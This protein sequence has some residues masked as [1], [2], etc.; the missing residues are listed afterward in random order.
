MHNKAPP[1]S[2]KVYTCPDCGK[3]YK[4]PVALKKHSY[5]HNGKELPFGCNICGKRFLVNIV[6][7]EHLM[8][9]AGIKNYVCPY[10][11]LGFTSKP[12]CNKHINTHTREKTFKCPQCD[13]STH[14][15]HLLNRHIRVIHD[16]IKK[17]ICQYCSKAFSQSNTWRNHEKL[18]TGERPY[19]CQICDKNYIYA[20]DLKKHLRS[21]ENK[22]KRALK[23]EEKNALKME[24]TAGKKKRRRRKKIY[25][26]DGNFV[27]YEPPKNP[28]EN[29]MANVADPTN[30]LM[31]ATDILKVCEETMP[32][33]V[34]QHKPRV[35]RISLE[36]FAGTFVNPIPAVDVPGVPIVNPNW[37]IEQNQDNQQE[38]K[39]KQPSNKFLIFQNHFYIPFPF[40]RKLPLYHVHHHLCL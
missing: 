36:H 15:K 40:N 11:G 23:R 28:E 3:V 26:A 34:K 25:D 9:H 8:R 22:A 27:M 10:C 4:C 17:Y 20:S 13:H 39:P 19:E 12:E 33:I 21:H 14:T 18:H 1:K 6:L 32:V 24:K 35:E 7:K 5:K 30:P 31:A 2:N 37:T 38:Q 16:K 29:Q